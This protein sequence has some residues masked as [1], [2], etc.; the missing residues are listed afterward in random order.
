MRMPSLVTLLIA[1]FCEKSRY[2]INLIRLKRESPIRVRETPST[3][4]RRAQR[5]AFHRRDVRL[6]SKLF[7]RWNQSLRR[8]AT[9]TG[10]AEVVGYYLPVALL[11]IVSL[12]PSKRH[13]KSNIKRFVRR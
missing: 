9:R 1:L 6:Q 8:S 5:N 11:M 10:F 13:D 3:F 2:L 7:A 4:H 12:F